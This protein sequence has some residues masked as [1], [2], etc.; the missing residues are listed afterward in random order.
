M[1]ATLR[2]WRAVYAIALQETIAYKASMAIWILTDVTT[3]ITMPLVWASAAKSGAIQGYATGE[4]TLYYLATLLVTSFVTSHLMWD[5]AFQ[6]REGIF[7]IYLVRPISYYQYQFFNNI[8]WRTIRPLLALPFVLLLALL[9]QPILKGAH[10][11]LSWEFWA[12]LFLGHLVSYFM[13]MAMAMISLFVQEAFAIFELY[14][15]P[16]LFLSGYMFPIALL[17]DWAQTITKFLPFYYTVG[18]PVE[19]VVGKLQ[20]PDVYRVLGMQAAWIVVSY[21]AGQWLWRKGL[22]HYTAVGM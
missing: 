20:G 19:I 12:A 22:K 2:K 14:Y 10:V 4:M 3:A 13:V 17:P 21:F 1:L 18:A 9:Y 11:H 7:S 15:V 5:V 8:A 6:I 16:H